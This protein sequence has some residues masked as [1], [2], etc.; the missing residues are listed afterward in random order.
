MIR[1]PDLRNE[2]GFTLLELMVV[3]VILGALLLMTLS[4]LAGI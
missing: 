3:A 1:V 2:E 4:T